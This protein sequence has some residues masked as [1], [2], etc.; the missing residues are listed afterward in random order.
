MINVGI[1]GH[2][3]LSRQRLYK[4]KQ[5]VFKI[6]K[7]LQI[8]HKKIK[9]ITPLADGADRLVVYQGLK[10]NINFEVILPMEKNEYKKDFNFYSKK[11]FDSLMKKSNSIITIDNRSNISRD[12]KYEMVGKYVS[13]NSDILIALW[14]GKYNNLQGGTSEI[15]KYHLKNKKELWHLKVD[16]N[17]I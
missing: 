15:V 12:L 14:D 3:D 6:L 16:R 4:Y 10:L 2:R 8:K 5:N 1:I 7:L 9:I 11:E 13:E 17:S